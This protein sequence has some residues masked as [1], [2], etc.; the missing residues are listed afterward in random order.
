MAPLSEGFRRKAR[1]RTM[2]MCNIDEE[3]ISLF[4]VD[5]VAELREHRR[6]RREA[7][8]ADE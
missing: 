6:A 4:L 7:G 8:Q 2:F 1:D 3:V 5:D